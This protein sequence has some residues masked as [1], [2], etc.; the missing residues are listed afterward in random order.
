MRPTRRI[1]LDGGLTLILAATALVALFVSAPMAFA[2]LDALI[3]DKPAS[4]ARC[5]ASWNR[6]W[7]A[8]RPRVTNAG[9]SYAVVRTI[10][11][12]NRTK[13][14]RDCSI[15]FYGM[16]GTISVRGRWSHGR[17]SSWRI[18]AI[19]AP[20]PTPA[21]N[22]VVTRGSHLSVSPSGKR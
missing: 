7:Q 8:P 22:A 6:S 3:V 11:R 16:R 15:A 2:T 14:F 20:P 19:D 4:P 9:V 1:G 21:A 18:T 12:R 17:V 5:A 10:P 13:T